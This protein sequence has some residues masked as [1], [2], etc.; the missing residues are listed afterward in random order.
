M[1]YF[2]GQRMSRTLQEG[3]RAHEITDSGGILYFSDGTRTSWRRE[4]ER[5]SCPDWM[6]WHMMDW[7][8]VA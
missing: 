8:V 1:N 6:P 4:T 5:L 3:M 7:R 2:L